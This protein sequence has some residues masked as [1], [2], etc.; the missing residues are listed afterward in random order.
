MSSRLENATKALLISTSFSLVFVREGEREKRNFSV[1]GH[2]E[3]PDKVVNI[4]DVLTRCNMTHF[5]HSARPR[6][7][8]VD[9]VVANS[10]DFV[11][12]AGKSFFV[13]YWETKTCASSVPSHFGT[14]ARPGECFRTSSIV[15]ANLFSFF[16]GKKRQ[17]LPLLSSP[18]LEPVRSGKMFST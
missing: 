10:P 16:V 6:A 1:V 18:L 7:R 14:R 9:C 17:V 13:F 12:R 5:S 8:P 11:R 2:I 3:K 4:R 15:A